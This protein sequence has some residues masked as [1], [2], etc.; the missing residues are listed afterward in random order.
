MKI[1]VVIVTYNGSTWIRLALDS[2]RASTAPCTALVVDNA[3]G[4]DTVDIV[5]R[6]YPEAVL[7]PQRENTGFGIGN[8]IGISHALRAE[9]DFIFLLNQDAYVTPTALAQLAG[10]LHAHPGYGL[11]TPLHC[12]PDLDTLDPQTQSR[13]LQG[14][15]PYYLSDACLG[16]VKPHYDIVGINAAAWMVRA[17]AFRSA[18]GF[19][20]LFFMYGE[21]DDLITRMNA[22]GQKFALL[23][24][25][26]IVHLRAKGPRR[27]MTLPQEIWALSERARSGLLLDA[28]LPTGSTAGKLIRLL[29][30]GIALPVLQAL[31][32]HNWKDALAFP[33]AAGRVLLQWRSI[34]ASARRCAS[35]GP[36]YLDI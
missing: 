10:F 23:P 32:T 17:G 11:A 13:Y 24:E 6:E 18:G 30:S 1:F 26:R 19:D 9:A 27:K 8:N 7:L 35:A 5:R 2:L 20:P 14:Y 22:L 4:D 34:A 3:S 15:A 12:S 31:V 21:D 28:K 16:R 29:V 25:S 33:L 36:H